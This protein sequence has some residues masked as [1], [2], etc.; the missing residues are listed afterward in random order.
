MSEQDQ[1]HMK[2]ALTLARKGIGKT[3]PNPAVGCVVVKDGR[4]VGEGWHQKAGQPH[5]E[6]NALAMAGA[7]AQGADV[8]VTLEPCSHTGRTPPCAK[9]LIAAGVRR[10]VAGMV[11]PNPQVAGKGF[12]L[13]RKAGIIVEHGVMEAECRAINR[14]F[15]KH[16]TT[17]LPYVTYK[18]AMTLDGNIATVTGESQWI[19][20]LDSRR[21]THRLRAAHDA[22]MVGVDTIIADNPQLTVR[23]VKG[24]NPQ[25]IIV[26]TRLRT[27]ESVG[28][29][30]ESMAHDTI[31][32]TTESNPRVHLRYTRQG[33]TV[34]VC[35]EYDGRVSMVDLLQKLGKRGIQSILLEGGSRLAG[36]MLQNN[37]IDEFIFFLAPKIIGSDG[38]AP[39]TLRGITSMDQAIKLQFGQIAHSGQDI[40]VHAW[41]AEATC[42][43]A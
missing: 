3:S 30:S 38:F 36:E 37:A 15:I 22:I 8:F 11:D 9:A 4:V 14:P 25:R 24:R 35:D 7:E 41:P 12:A 1:R 2:R 17:G 27:P 39:F 43:P 33:A 18:C 6:V 16:I 13:L 26:D 40:I 23:H 29:L 10:V 21:Y 19:S 5:A 20:C 34:V 42:S 32:A 28:V 31:I